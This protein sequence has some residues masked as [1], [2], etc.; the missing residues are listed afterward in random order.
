MATYKIYKRTN[1]SVKYF[2]TAHNR[3]EFVNILLSNK[4]EYKYL[5]IDYCGFDL[6]QIYLA[7]D[8]DEIPNYTER[9]YSYPKTK[10]RINDIC[11]EVKI[12]MYKKVELLFF[13]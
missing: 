6:W 2:D 7:R 5:N 8:A 4:E 3:E 1:G 10:R 11:R 13:S 9:V 12:I